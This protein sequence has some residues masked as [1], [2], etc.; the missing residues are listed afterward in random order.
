MSREKKLLKNTIILTFGKVFTQMIT[1]FLL[2][3]YTAVLST[4]EFGIVDLLNTLVSL[5]V[6]I[7]S[8]QLEQAVFR[9]LIDARN[10]EDQ[11]K[12]VISTSFIA[13]LFQIVGYIIIFMI[14]YP[15]IKNDYKI[16][17]ITNVFVYIFASYFQQ[18]ARGVDKPVDYAIG[19]FL[20]GVF[21]IITNILFII[22]LGL[23]ANG[24]LLGNMIGQIICIIYITVR[25]NV[26]KFINIKNVDFSLL[27]QLYKYSMPLIPNAVS[28]WIFNASDRIIVSTFLGISKNGILSAS[29][30][31]SSL[32]IS[33]FSIFN[34]SWTEMI[35]VHI[36]DN[37]IQEFF[38]KMFNV[39]VRFFISIAV[40]ITACMPFV[41]P[42]MIDKNYFFGYYQV[43]IMMLGSVFNILI[44]LLGSIYV[45]KKNTKAIANTAIVSAIINIIVHLLLINTL[46]L[47]AAAIS[48]ACAYFMMFIYRIYDV[49]KK[50]F[51]VQ[52]ECGILIKSV[53]ISVITCV[54]YYSENVIFQVISLIIVII[55][56]VELNKNSFNILF[57]VIKN[58]FL[59]R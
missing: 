9:N 58:K 45:A 38:N 1:F 6:P 2:P 54:A 10:D 24:M 53:L 41:Y 34:M 59:H 8:F 31:F 15:Y 28:W 11:K 30:K 57:G 35:S 46:D 47:Y 50:Y 16:F 14:I 23:G 27:K 12:K 33:F 36:N 7:I 17:L 18:V 55:Y 3:I 4:E 56:A 44:G 5:M 25:L 22:G 29:H 26:L 49:N 32:Y 48:T 42:I 19:S 21:T 20:S 39:S 40:G 37:D 13:I 52:F 51:K 43:P